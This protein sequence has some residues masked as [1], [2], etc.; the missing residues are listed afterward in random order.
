VLSPTPALVRAAT[1]VES[2]P[3]GDPGGAVQG[4]SSSQ[5]TVTSLPSAGDGG[6]GPPIP[7]R[8]VT[9]TVIILLVGAGSWVLYYG[10]REVTAED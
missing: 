4:Q 7:W 9:A 3:Q 8:P 6:A 1:T 10:L 5:G 2:S